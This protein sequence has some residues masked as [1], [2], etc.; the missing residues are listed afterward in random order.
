[1]GL[2]EQ[3]KLAGRRQQGDVFRAECALGEEKH[4]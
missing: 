2:E 4:G 1:M 3:Q